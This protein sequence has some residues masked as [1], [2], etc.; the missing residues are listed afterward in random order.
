MPI[1]TY[2]NFHLNLAYSSIEEERRYV[3]I[4][5]CYWPILRLTEDLQFPVGIEA[6]AYTL[7]C[8]ANID[9]SWIVKLKELINIG[10]IE[11]VGSGYAQI[12]GPLVPAKV[13][14]ANLHLG[15]KIYESLLGVRPKTALINEQ[16]YS[17]GL[18]E[19]YKDAGYEAIIIEWN[20]PAHCHPEWDTEWQYYPQYARN[21]NGSRI[22]IIWNNSVAF[23]KFQRYAHGDMELEEHLGYLEQY[24]NRDSGMFPLYGNDVEIFDFRPGRYH[25]EAALNRESEWQRIR[26]LYTKLKKDNRIQMVK[27]GD[28]LNLLDQS[29]A[30][31]VL[32]IESPEQPVSVKKQAKY[33][34]TRWAVTGRDDLGINTACWHIYENLLQTGNK[35]DTDWQELCYLWSSDFRT[36]IT[37]K[38]WQAYKKRLEKFELRTSQKKGEHK[39]ELEPIRFKKSLPVNT[40]IT[41]DGRYMTVE[42][43]TIKIKL[44]CRRGL[45]INGLWEAGSERPFWCGTLPHGFYNDIAVDFD[46]YTG[47]TVIECLGKPKVTDLNPVEPKINY[48]EDSNNI[49]VYGS[50]QT[51]EGEVQKSIFIS[52]REA[53]INLDYKFHLGKLP[54]GSFRLGNITLNPLTFD[55]DSLFYRTCNGGYQPET[56]LL[57]DKEFDHGSPVSFLVSANNCVGMTEGWIEIGDAKSVLRVEVDKSLAAMVGLLTYKKVNDSYFLR[58][59]LSAGEWDETRRLS[60]LVLDNL[61]V[62]MKIKLITP[63]I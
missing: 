40:G 51:T 5:K 9:F 43:P 30:G 16:A 10:L 38:R 39:K 47:H 54:A 7:E 24:W 60:D 33:N 25:T 58:L 48:I 45:S 19:L 57:K 41:R 53:A 15:I 11:F 2:I 31:K 22:P 32:T 14:E 12:I 44:D 23:Q 37:E 36:H 50:I 4:E 63:D 35:N 55:Q 17:S 8:I 28:V 27:P 13:N 20:N 21:N 59:S 29:K 1:S 34:I 26:L 61:E 52:C 46:W 62:K 56:F 3:V 6:S 18:I 49:L 42:T